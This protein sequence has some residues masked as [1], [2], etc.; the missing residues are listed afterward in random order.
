MAI[1]LPRHIVGPASCRAVTKILLATGIGPQQIA[2]AAGL[3]NARVTDM[4]DT[5][6]YTATNAR[7]DGFT[8]GTWLGA[9]GTVERQALF[10]KGVRPIMALIRNATWCA[11]VV[12]A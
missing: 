6:L 1:A 2:H 11:D 5:P 3:R 4:P 12:W 7:L 10:G 8:L 9:A